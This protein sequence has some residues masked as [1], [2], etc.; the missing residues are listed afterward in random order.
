MII[1]RYNIKIES[2]GIKKKPWEIKKFTYSEWAKMDYDWNN[3]YKVKH[4]V[5]SYLFRYENFI[6]GN[7]N[8]QIMKSTFGVKN[9]IEIRKEIEYWFDACIGA[10]SEINI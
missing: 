8:S 5:E 1:S 4:N 9:N 2:D 3:E 10:Y 6:S 7:V